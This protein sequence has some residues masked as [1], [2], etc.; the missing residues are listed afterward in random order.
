M[1]AGARLRNAI[2]AAALLLAA[3][4]MASSPEVALR[5]GPFAFQYAPRLTDAQLEWYGRFDVLVTHDPLPA[6]QVRTLHE[7][8]TKLLFYEWSVAFYESRATSWQKSLLA[9]AKRGLLHD[10]ALRG[11]VGSPTSPAWYFDPAAEG[12]LLQRT[13]DLVAKLEATGYDGIFFDTT[14]FESV[15]PDARAAFERR[16]PGS[17]YDAAFAQLLAGLR[18][19]GALVFTNQ[20][21]RDPGELLPHTD[22]DLT[23]SLITRPRSDG[24]DVRTWS[25]ASDPWNSIHFVLRTMLEPLQREHPRVRFAHLNYIDAPAPEAVRLAVAVAQLFD[26]EAFTAA[27]ALD[28]E[29]DEIYFR[30]PGTALGDRFDWEE[31]RGAHRFFTNGLIAVSASPVAHTITLDGRPLRN[32]ATGELACNGAVTIPPSPAGA[33]A[34]FF[35]V[36]TACNAETGGRRG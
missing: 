11:G 28:H 19:H 25:S 4:V 26:G 31:E 34:W 7:A 2:A 30:D 10:R 18:Q 15:H 21:Y 16:H 9:G 12:H 17:S 24:V 32:R 22:W 5:R 13:S 23:E 35:D 6:E 14:R 36:S 1:L 3:E 27:R 33:T 8:G 20:G 29:C